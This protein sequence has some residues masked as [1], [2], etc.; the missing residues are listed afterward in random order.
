MGADNVKMHEYVTN[1][2]HVGGVRFY[3]VGERCLAA[4][5][6]NGKIALTFEKE[7]I[8]LDKGWYLKGYEDPVAM[9]QLEDDLF[10]EAIESALFAIRMVTWLKQGLG[11]DDEQQS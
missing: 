10:I 3:S 9:R 2:I 6:Q 11:E 4:R 7:S 1:A 5:L 8:I